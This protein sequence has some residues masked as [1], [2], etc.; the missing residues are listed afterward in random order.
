[1]S[2]T[3][4]KR[5]IAT[6]KD[7]KVDWGGHK[8][9]NGFRCYLCGTKFAVGDGYRYVYTGG[10]SFEDTAGKK[11]GVMNFLTCDACDGPNVIAAWVERNRQFA[12]DTSIN[13]KYWAFGSR[14]G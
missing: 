7:C 8:N 2:F 10:A 9:N 12:R 3:D 13:G 14:E 11:F 4:Q 1:M 5:Q 6:E